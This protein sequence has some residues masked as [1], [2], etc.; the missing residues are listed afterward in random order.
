MAGLRQPPAACTAVVDAPRRTSSEA[1]PRR[2]ECMSRATAERPPPERIVCAGRGARRGTN[3]ISA[4]RRDGDRHRPHLHLERDH[5]GQDHEVR[6]GPRRRP[7][8]TSRAEVGNSEPRAHPVDKCEYLQRSIEYALKALIT[9]GG[10]R[11]RHLHSLDGMWREAEATGDTV[12]ATRDPK[13]SGETE[14]VRRAVALRQTAGRRG[15]GDNVAAEPDHRR[16]RPQPRPPARAATARADTRGAREPNPRRHRRRNA[17]G[18]GN[19]ARPG[20][21]NSREPKPPELI[22]GTPSSTRRWRRTTALRLRRIGRLD[23]RGARPRPWGPAS[24]GAPPESFTK[25]T[26]DAI[27]SDEMAETGLPKP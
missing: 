17:A 25:S 15:P 20:T 26:W 8:R 12:A 22:D 11:V 10:R 27:R 16:G 3:G 23:P 6:T 1:R 13:Q 4:R 7:A 19:A 9:A 24:N 14:P 2:P 21:G 5:D 18:S